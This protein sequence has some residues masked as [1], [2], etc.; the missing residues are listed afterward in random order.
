VPNLQTSRKPDCLRTKPQQNKLHSAKSKQDDFA[1][2]QS[3]H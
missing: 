1:L 3:F 2:A